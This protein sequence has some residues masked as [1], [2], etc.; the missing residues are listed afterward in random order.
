MPTKEECFDQFELVLR[1]IIFPALEA[2]D[3]FGD[4]GP[5]RRAS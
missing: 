4:E 5:D 3:Q 1:E 2:R